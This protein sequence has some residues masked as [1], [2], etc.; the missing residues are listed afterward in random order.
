MFYFSINII[1]NYL[2]TNNLLRDIKHK[3]NNTT[4]HFSKMLYIT[5][6]KLRGLNYKIG[7]ILIFPLTCLGWL[8][9]LREALQA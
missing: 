5:L 8:R 6:E 9:G 2:K 1:T 3:V 4:I 7:G